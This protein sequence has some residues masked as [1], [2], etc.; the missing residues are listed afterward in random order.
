MT[1][2][3]FKTNFINVMKFYGEI[4]AKVCE[5]RVLIIRHDGISC[6]AVCGKNLSER[7][8]KDC[9]QVQSSHVSFIIRVLQ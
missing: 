4:L 5:I 3:N 1:N 9:F 7:V 6:Q 8:V 2:R